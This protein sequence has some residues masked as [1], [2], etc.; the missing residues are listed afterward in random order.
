VASDHEVLLS[1]DLDPHILAGFRDALNRVRTA[2]WA[3]QQ[4]RK[5]TKVRVVCCRCWSGKEFGNLP[6]LPSDQRR[7]E[8]ELISNFKQAAL[9]NFTRSR[10]P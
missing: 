2:A 10:R 6:A 4:S 3:A 9:F 1:G 8:N 5:R 7:L